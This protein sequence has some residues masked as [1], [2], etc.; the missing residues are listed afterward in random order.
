METKHKTFKPFDKVLVRHNN[1]WKIEFYSHYNAECNNHT[2]TAGTGIV[3]ENILSYEGNEHLL[4]TTNEPEEEVKLEEGEWLYVSD[5]IAQPIT[6]W[7]LSVFEETYDGAFETYTTK[8]H[9]K[10]TSE[11]PLYWKYAIKFSDFNP[12]DMEETKKHILCVENG[13]VVRYYTAEKQGD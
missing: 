4:G 7:R 3:D 13:K 2:V 5:A 8:K 9:L 1:K 11:L 10:I 6:D 12:N